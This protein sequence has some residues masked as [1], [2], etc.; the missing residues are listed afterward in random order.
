MARELFLPAPSPLLP[1]LFLS[2]PYPHSSLPP[3]AYPNLFSPPSTHPLP[4]T[5]TRY[6]LTLPVYLCPLPLLSLFPSGSCLFQPILSPLF[7]STYTRSLLAL[8]LPSPAYSIFSFYPYTFYLPIPTSSTFPLPLPSPA[9]SLSPPP[10]DER[11]EGYPTFLMREGRGAGDSHIPLTP[12]GGEE[13]G[14]R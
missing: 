12:L 2:L 9:Y 7:L 11:D 13:R 1:A 5:Y 4:I 3:S 14:A 8:S 10:S 6:L